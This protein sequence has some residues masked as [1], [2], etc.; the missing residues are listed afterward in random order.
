MAGY[1][2]EERLCQRER[3]RETERD[4]EKESWRGGGGRPLNS[5]TLVPTGRFCC[6][7]P[8]P[9]LQDRRMKGRGVSVLAC[10]ELAVQQQFGPCCL[11][12]MRKRVTVIAPQSPSHICRGASRDDPFHL[13]S[14]PNLPFPHLATG[15]CRP[16]I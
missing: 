3:E 11:T 4:R 7:R 14:S 12:A 5:S 6:H 2:R 15:T 8:S 1:E 9:P 13:S 16:A 10:P